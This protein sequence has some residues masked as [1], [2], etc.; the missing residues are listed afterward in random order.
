MNGYGMEWVP[1]RLAN[2]WRGLEPR[3]RTHASML[4][5][6]GLIYTVH[7]LVYCIP[8]PFYI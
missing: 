1:E 6:A 8:Q 3:A 2:W 4:V 7:Y 5:V